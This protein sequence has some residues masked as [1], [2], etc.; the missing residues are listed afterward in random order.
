MSVETSLTQP[1]GL[2]HA[3][4]TKRLPIASC[5]ARWIAG[6][7]WDVALTL[8]FDSNVSRDAAVRAA[9]VYWQGIDTELFGSN[10]VRRHKIRLQ[11]ACFIEGETGVRNWHFHAAVQLPALDDCRWD[12]AVVGSAERFGDLLVERWREMREAGRFSKAEPI[13]DAA[14]WATY[15]SKDA[16]K[17]ECDLCTTTSHLTFDSDTM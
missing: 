8:N 5:Y 15:I 11:R 7:R 17:G 3:A 9:R 13:Y 16:G 14:G 12:A 10:A 1:T 6:H 4:R 2:L